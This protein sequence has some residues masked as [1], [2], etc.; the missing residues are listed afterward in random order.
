MFLRVLW[1]LN[2]FP[3]SFG[4]CKVGTA[5]AFKILDKDRPKVG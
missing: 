1:D 3:I 5:F 4:K 2:V